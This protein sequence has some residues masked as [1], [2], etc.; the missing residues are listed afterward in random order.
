[1]EDLLPRDAKWRR[2]ILPT[3]NTPGVYWSRCSSHTLQERHWTQQIPV[4]RVPSGLDGCREILLTKADCA[5]KAKSAE[6]EVR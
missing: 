1:M 4:R 5:T 3:I 2:L 6:I